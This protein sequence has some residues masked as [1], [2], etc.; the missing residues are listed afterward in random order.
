MTALAG[1]VHAQN[2]VNFD[3]PSI[4]NLQPVTTQY[5]AEG[6]VFSGITWDGQSVAL[7]ANQQDDPFD[8]VNPPSTPNAL[9][10]FYGGDPDSRAEVMQIEFLAPA[11]DISFLYNPA[12]GDGVNTVFNVYNTSDALIESFSDLNASGDGV[13]YTET[14]NMSDVGEV[15][16]VAPDQGWGH[17]IDNLSFTESASAPDGGLTVALLGGA[18]VA[19]AAMRRK[20]S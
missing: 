3:D 19:L 15:D 5:A 6:V 2:F 20:I 9:S 17:Y 18:F 13:Y 11:S 1:M 16:I 14:I 12:G 4:G 8:D 10:D 7:D